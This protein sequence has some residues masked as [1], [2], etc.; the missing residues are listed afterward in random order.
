MGM[1]FKRFDRDQWT[2]RAVPRTRPTYWAVIGPRKAWRVEWSNRRKAWRLPAVEFQVLDDAFH[3]KPD[4]VTLADELAKELRLTL[5]IQAD[6]FKHLP[7]GW[8]A[9]TNTT[10]KDWLNMGMGQCWRP[11][12]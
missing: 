3:Y 5:A 9:N 2:G 7:A 11:A 4:G 1:F 12:S 10:A 8:R 6:P